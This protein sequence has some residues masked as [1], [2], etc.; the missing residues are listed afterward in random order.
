MALALFTGACA[1]GDEGG[2]SDERGAQPGVSGIDDQGEPVAGG[3]LV[4]ALE[5]ESS[6]GWCLPESQLAISGIQIARTIYDTLTAPDENGDI[7]PF[8]AQSVEPNATFDEWTVTLREGVTFHDGTP[9]DAQVVANNLDAYR[10][11]YRA[12]N[13]LLYRFVFSNI[14]AVTVTGP[15]TVTVT[16]ATPWPSLPWFL[17]NSGRIGMIAQAQLDDAESCD[18]ELIGTGPFMLDD[19]TVNQSFTAVKNPHYWQTDAD[20]SQLPY[21]D[22]IEYRPVPDGSQRVNLLQSGEVDLMH[23]AL[24]SHI[25]SLRALGDDIGLIESDAFGEIGYLMLN[26]AEATADEPARVFNSLTA[27]RAAAHAIDRER[28]ISVRGLDIPSIA[29]GPFAPGN[30]G[31]LEETGFPDFDLERA[32][33]LVAQYE[34][35]SG[36]ELRIVLANATDP[37]LVATGDMLEEML[38]EAGIQVDRSQFEQAQLI[39]NALGGSFDMIQWR[40]HP[41]GHPDLQYNWWATGSPVNFGKIEDPELQALLD[42]GRAEPDPAAATAIYEDVNRRF[43]EQLYNLW[44][45]FTIWTIGT[46]P[47]VS[48][49]LGP[50]LPDG[51]GPFPGLAAGH[52]V[53]GLWIA[54]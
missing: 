28:L 45:T 4:Y 14:S 49:V 26:V 35:E 54:D 5:A 6:G 15:L 12:R 48:G 53:S 3:D 19:W 2:V 21:L 33:D 50:D 42:A 9:L 37:D 30:V 17:F 24:P 31:Y 8:L 1:G 16:T 13:P 34:E 36:Q 7:R 22:S 51:G 38:T 10:G 18:R 46:D 43:A 40:N 25:D 27:R 23:T 20:G 39:N 29:Q 41:G 52:P 47:D 32:K 44:Q 11:A